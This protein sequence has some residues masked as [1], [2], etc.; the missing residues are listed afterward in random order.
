MMPGMPERRTHDYL[1]HGITT[2][3]AALDVATGGDRLDPPPT[4]GRG[5]EKACL[6]ALKQHVPDGR[7]AVMQCRPRVT[8][9]RR[10]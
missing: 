3:F 2:L 7:G 4:P 5:A 10:R 1:R 9:R 6:D 8:D